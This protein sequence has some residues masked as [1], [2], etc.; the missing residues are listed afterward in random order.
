MGCISDNI[1]LCMHCSTGRRNC[2]AHE[3]MHTTAVDL[4]VVAM[5]MRT[6]TVEC[7]RIWLQLHSSGVFCLSLQNLSD[8]VTA[9]QSYGVLCISIRMFLS[10]DDVFEFILMTRSGCWV[11]HIH[12]YI[13][14]RGIFP[15][16]PVSR[17]LVRHVQMWFSP[18]LGLRMQRIHSSIS[19]LNLCILIG[20]ACA[21]IVRVITC[22]SL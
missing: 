19:V 6:G 15:L 2:Y 4:L 8:H 7:I 20:G 11:V 14:C 13:T 9:A 22:I 17:Q 5:L 3:C 10:C 18:R 21:N 1:D 12:T 16:S